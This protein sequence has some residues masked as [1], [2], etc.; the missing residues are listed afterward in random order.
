MSEGEFTV[1]LKAAAKGDREATSELTRRVYDELRDI[2]HARLRKHRHNAVLRTSDVVNDGLLRLI[3]SG[4]PDFESRRAF[5]RA[6]SNAMR[7]V[8]V[9]E[10]RRR[11]TL[12]RD[13]ARN[14]ELPEHDVLGTGDAVSIDDALAVDEA[15]ARLRGEHP[16]AA[17]GVELRY[18]G[19]LT[20]P[21]V[22][23]VV[24]VSLATA[25]R[26]WQFARAWLGH[27]LSDEGA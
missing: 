15:L 11:G 5:L 10:A 3:G 13:A 9:D 17:E 25:E 27:A 18:F 23:E 7:N 4:V 24:G 19:G 16:R 21:E 2:A 8:I 14:R 1:L 6:A 22:A 26:D 20:M 12:K